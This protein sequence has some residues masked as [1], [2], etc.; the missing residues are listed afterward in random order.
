M[1]EISSD[2]SRMLREKAS[3]LSR[4][5]FFVDDDLDELAAHRGG[6]DHLDDVVVAA[7]QRV[8]GVDDGAVP[9]PVA[10]VDLVVDR[11]R[12]L[13][14]GE[15]AALLPGLQRD[16]AGADRVENLARHVLRHHAARRHLEHQ[17]GGVGGRQPVVEQA[18]PVIGDR[19][20]IDQ[21]LRDH[22]EQDRED[23]E[24]ARQSQ[25]RRALAGR[26]RRGSIRHYFNTLRLAPLERDDFSNCH[27][28][29]AHCWSRI[30][31][32]NR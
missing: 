15:Q 4:S 5:G 9:A 11:V 3:I 32:E 27:S 10:H 30:F 28:V 26:S 8:E 18:Q 24:L 25:A 1:P 19:R 29:L 6:A 2:S 13:G 21:H 14:G 20:D 31:P 12:H 16:R 22:H 23:E 17:R 7:D